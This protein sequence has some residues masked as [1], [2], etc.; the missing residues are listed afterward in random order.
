M[1]RFIS[2]LLFFLYSFS[3]SGAVLQLHFCGDDF[4]SMSVN[5]EAASDCCCPIVKEKKDNNLPKFQKKSCCSEKDLTLK[6]DLDQSLS[7][8]LASLQVLQA[9][10]DVPQTASFSFA[11]EFVS[12]TSENTYRSNAPPKGLWQQIPLYR[13]L[14][15]A[16]YYD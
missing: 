13:L 4:H 6:I 16:V 7:N 3:V 1:K 15:R 9:S 11:K 2:I 12:N 8:A 5:T 10:A 14:Q